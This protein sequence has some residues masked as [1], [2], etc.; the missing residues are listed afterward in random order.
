VGRYY[1]D[2]VEGPGRWFGGGSDALGLDGQVAPAHL[3]RILSGEHPGT[4]ATLRRL[5][6]PVREHEDNHTATRSGDVLTLTEAAQIAGMS[7]RTL[8]QFAARVERSASQAGDSAQA[9][10]REKSYLNASRNDDGKW[11]VTRAELE[12][13]MAARRPTK[14]VIGYD[15]T[16]SAPKSVSI[17]W[18]VADAKTQREIADAVES[19]V[20]AGLRYLESM[21]S[22][23]A[24]TRP[25]LRGLV[26]AAFLHGT[27][28]NLDPQLHVHAIVAN[29]AL[30]PDDQCRA[31][32]GRDLFAHAKTAGYLAAAHLRYECT[33]RFGWRWGPVIHGLADIV[34]VPAEAIRAMSSRRQEIE[35]LAT[36]SGVHSAPARQVAAYRTRTA[37]EAVA[38]EEMQAEWD[39]R[40]TDAG[41]DEDARVRCFGHRVELGP[42]RGSDRDE[43]LAHLASAR[44]VTERT[45]VFDRRH[46]IQAV[47]AW[48]EARLSAAEMLD[49]ADAFLASEQAIP[50]ARTDGEVIRLQGGRIAP[51]A[52]G[53]TRYSTPAMLTAERQVLD[54]FE[55]GLDRGVGVVAP[56]AIEAAIAARPSLGEDQAAM[57]RT[58][59]SSGDQLQCVLGPAGSGKTFALDA[60]R[61]AWQ[62]AGY[63]VIGAAEQGTAAEV[64]ALGT[65][66]RAETLEYWLTLLDTQPQAGIFS[67]RTVLLVDEAST[68]GTRSLARLCRHAQSSGTVVRLVGDP[69][70]HTAVSAGG[71]FPDLVTRYRQRTP[72][73]T[74]LRR[75]AGPEL[76]Q[77]RLALREYR[78]GQIVQSID[79]LH[80]DDR[81]VLA[82]NA[83]QLLDQLATDWWVDRQH[84]LAD[85]SR[86]PSSMVAEH[87][88][89]RRA[90][91][92]RARVL[93]AANGDLHGPVFHA[94]AHEFQAGD[95][96]ICRAPAKK[97]HPTGHPRR[98]LRNGTR[99]TVIS[100]DPDGLRP[101]IVVD[102]EYRGPI[103]VPHDFLTRELRPG[104][105]GGL[106]YSYALT[107]HAAQGHTHHVARTLATDSSSRPG[108]YVGLT[109]GQTDSRLYAVR[110]RDLEGD[111]EAEDH[112][113]RLH[114]EK[115][116]LE[117]V[118]DRLITHDHEHLATTRD[119]TAAEVA[120]LRDKCQLGELVA[121]H[122]NA[123]SEGNRALVARA[124]GARR[125]ALARAARLAPSP[126]LVARVGQRP[127]TPTDRRTWDAAAGALAVRAELHEV[128]DHDARTLRLPDAARAA[129]LVR[130]AEIMYLARR[131][132]TD[133]A[134]EIS[135]LTEDLTTGGR[136]S[137]LRRLQVSAALVRADIA[138][139]TA[140]GR[141]IELRLPNE[142][143]LT[144]TTSTR[145][146]HDDAEADLARAR[147]HHDQ[148][149][150][151]LA[152]IDEAP[153][154][155]D[156]VADR[157]ERLRAALDHQI[158]RSV[159]RARTS[160]PQYVVDLIGE[161]PAG[162]TGRPWDDRVRQLEA[163]RHRHG[164]SFGEDAIVRDAQYDERALGPRP[165]NTAAALAW[166][167]TL[168][169][170]ADNAAPSIESPVP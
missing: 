113:P 149:A 12:R 130:R 111:V 114:D 67:S 55:H 150:Q 110:R 96:V 99:G 86:A 49:L 42:L 108:I 79:R 91:N 19:A 148:L 161:R 23:R 151:R 168:D 169:A 97:L 57:V 74:E 162:D 32:D 84:R 154:A 7:S 101:G 145:R 18:A 112:L 129:N 103:R 29:L 158:D 53:L 98:Y 141:E 34:G 63:E 144:A 1:A 54:A 69:A 157:L 102:F 81:V 116:T 159:E 47:A 50:L 52:R 164:L 100:V 28:R 9:S 78:E 26:T 36:E 142:V 56:D 11:Q 94:G 155:H 85:L 135:R 88:R 14:A 64:L 61:H 89:E 44:G 60:A 41:F 128:P 4:G 16:F 138:V 5:G 121:L 20:D 35:S 105:H 82:D 30:R 118:T 45:A 125:D 17:L 92:I 8:R 146:A 65:G 77:L 163:F 170:L 124:V 119:P 156:Q 153:S 126:E 6:T 160:P 2:S 80:A 66:I 134:D 131:P 43:L 95:E 115:T 147:I 104:I 140:Q 75:Q 15:V 137:L 73:L 58:I 24:P 51:A 120:R 107:S 136:A 122:D 70:Q 25:V 139:N 68:V 117:A 72:E 40:L 87:H 93:L 166:D 133:L 31:L 13:F 106:T 33:Q 38:P 123:A 62:N 83:E 109:R 90:L 143:Q 167:L 22:T 165:H 132:T 127:E 152:L 21:T 10:Q 37:K 3:E 39:Q 27:S 48:S 46:V 59:C 76:A 71:A